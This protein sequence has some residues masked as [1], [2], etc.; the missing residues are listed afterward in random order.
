[1]DGTKP[2]QITCIFK[3]G[4]VASVSPF[5][6]VSLYVLDVAYVEALNDELS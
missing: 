1:M 5:V 4:T 3:K 2:K 6:I